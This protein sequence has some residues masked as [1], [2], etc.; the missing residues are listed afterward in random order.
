MFAC[1]KSDLEGKILILDG[2]DEMKTLNI[3]DKLLMDFMVDIKDLLN[4]K[5]IITSRSA[6]INLDDYENII[7][8]K[9]LILKRPI[10]L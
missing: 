9:T 4:F 10:F 3:R 1:K 2:F 6:Y 8:L 7:E 5:C